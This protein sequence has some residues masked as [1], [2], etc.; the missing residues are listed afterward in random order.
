MN[1]YLTP[2]YEDNH[3]LIL[4]KPSG[5]ITQPSGTEQDS[6]EL[7]AKTWLKQVYGKPGNVF[8]QAVHR[9]DKPVSGI[10]VFGKTSKALSR[11]NESIRNKKTKKKYCAWLE[12]GPLSTEDTLE[13]FLIHDDHFARVVSESVSGAKL[14]RL[15]YRIVEYGSKE[16]PEAVR[17]EIELETGRY[18]QIRAQFSAIGCPILGDKKYGSSYCQPLD[19]IALHHHSLELIHPILKTSFFVEAPLPDFFS[20]PFSFFST[21]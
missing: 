2:L 6:L 8:L 1:Q 7:Q 14:S 13:H 3:L 4:N 10:V 16:K 12:R 9:L 11:L 15:H 18:H 21:Y 20:A 5:L 19:T 17:V